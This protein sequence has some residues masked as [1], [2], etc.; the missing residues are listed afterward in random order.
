LNLK[1][2]LARDNMLIAGEGWTGMTGLFLSVLSLCPRL[3]RPEAI[4]VT[5][6]RI[7][8]ALKMPWPTHLPLSLIL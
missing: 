2:G 6:I 1:E 8:T 4:A 3:A 7:Y 5:S